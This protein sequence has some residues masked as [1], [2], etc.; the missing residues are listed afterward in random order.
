MLES[1]IHWTRDR[2]KDVKLPS[3]YEI[4][5]KCGEKEGYRF[6]GQHLSLWLEEKIKE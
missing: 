2:G 6:N 3:R 4:R 5:L 1:S